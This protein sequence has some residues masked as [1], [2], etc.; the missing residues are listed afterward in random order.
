MAAVLFSCLLLPFSSVVAQSSGI[1][2]THVVTQE[3]EESLGLKA[4]FT[5]VDGNGRAV[6][7]ANLAGGSVELLG[8]ADVPREATISQPNTPFH[9]A[10]LLDGSGSMANVIGDVRVAAKTTLESAPP[11]AHFA[12]I[13]F[14][15]LAADAE[16]R[17]IQDFTND[18]NLVASA[19]DAVTAD[20]GA[21]TCLYNTVHKAIELLDKQIVN[22]Q[23]RRAIILFTDGKDETP[24]GAPCSQRDFDGVVYR[25][26]QS[27]PITPVHTI[28]L[29]SNPQCSNINRSE[30]VNLAEQTLGFSAIGGQTNLEALFTEIMDGLNS[31]W[32]AETNVLAKSGINQGILTAAVNNSNSNPFS[33]ISPPFQFA[34]DRDYTELREPADVRIQSITYNP[35]SDRFDLVLLTTSPEFIQ[36]IVV[37]VWD[38]RG[39]VQVTP[40]L[41]FFNP[42]L[43]LPL[44]LETSTLE[45]GREYRVQVQAIDTAGFLL[46]KPTEET[47][48]SDSEVQTILAQS[49]FVYEPPAPPEPEP[50]EFT[51]ES[52]N[53]NY[54]AETLTIDLNVLEESRLYAVEGFLK[55]SGGQKV[56]EFGPLEYEGKR[57]QLPMP[58]ALQRA[59]GAKYTVAVY[60]TTVENLRSETEYE[61]QPIAPGFFQRTGRWFRQNTTVVLSALVFLISCAIA[62]LFFQ[63]RR[64]D[65]KSM[66][67][68]RPPIEGTI[69]A[70][71]PE[72]LAPPPAQPEVS[73]GAPAMLNGAQ[74]GTASVNAA[75][76]NA[77]SLNIDASNGHGANGQAAAHV[78]SASQAR[79]AHVPQ[80]VAATEIGTSAGFSGSAIPYQN[81]QVA[82]EPLGLRLVF[83]KAVS[84]EPL[85]DT[86]VVNFP[87]VIG[88][89]Q[90]LSHGRMTQRGN[91]HFFNIGDDAKIS[92]S[93]IELTF[94]NGRYF[95][96][97][98]GSRNGTFIDGAQLDALQ[99]TCLEGAAAVHLGRRTHLQ[100]EPIS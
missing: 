1:V 84:D 100:L 63:N 49:T 66:L 98:L 64:E 53:T 4:F 61:F 37:N 7:D 48:S 77:A 20:A 51:I 46:E 80:A 31:Q 19:I 97:D 60:L 91:K 15:Q 10:M 26:T 72:V 75:S 76:V 43:S 86:I 28:G 81:G 52:A 24:S 73:I 89:D 18:R 25:A 87:F 70:I 35:N 45:A 92:R 32:L 67:P 42:G 34:S 57:I 62:W 30:L 3:E 29:C 47:I 71:D 56:F 59:N 95:V 88:R 8:G 6:T 13:K 99:P 2:I 78:Q 74:N 22:P 11:T 82:P 33:L 68:P 79:Q 44:E 36:R 27:G 50:V 12:V 41:N 93:H 58:P 23:E 54:E 17:P 65:K 55:N 69:S 5:L 14:N 9:I 40:D 83:T 39:G 94:V 96:T 90:E 85:P 21:S 16:L 38:T